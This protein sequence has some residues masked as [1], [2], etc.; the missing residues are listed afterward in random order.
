M[1]RIIKLIYEKELLI[2]LIMSNKQYY[3]LWGYAPKDL[4]I[5]M[6]IEYSEFKQNQNAFITIPFINHKDNLFHMMQLNKQEDF[7]VAEK[8]LKAVLIDE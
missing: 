6:D 8:I 4:F 7:E 3:I 2:G 1:N 5:N